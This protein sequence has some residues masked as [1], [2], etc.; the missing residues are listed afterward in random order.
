VKK[1]I[2][3]FVVV[4]ISLLS[5]NYFSIF[6]MSQTPG[7]QQSLYFEKLAFKYYGDRTYGRYLQQLNQNANLETLVSEQQLIVPEKWAMIRFY[8]ENRVSLPSNTNVID[9]PS[10]SVFR[11]SMFHPAIGIVVIVA[12][13]IGFLMGRNTQGV[14]F[15]KRKSDSRISSRNSEFITD[16]K[17]ISSYKTR[18]EFIIAYNKER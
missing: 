11:S 15:K 6:R 8:S 5:Y 9:F 3:F 12:L 10:D 4:G 2:I 1:I 7:N 17:E 13:I 18:D 14:F 16:V